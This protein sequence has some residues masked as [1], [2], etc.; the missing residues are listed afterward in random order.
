MKGDK[1]AEMEGAKMRV[2][3]WFPIVVLAVLAAVG[4]CTPKNV[5]TS[6]PTAVP[7]VSSGNPVPTSPTL[8]PEHAAWAKVVEAAKKEGLLTIYGSTGFAGDKGRITLAAFRDKYSIRVESLNM[9]G[10]QIV[11][12]VKVEERVSQPIAD[13]AA[14][15]TSSGTELSLARLVTKVWPE[16]PEMS[17]RSIFKVDPFHTPEGDVL[18]MVMSTLGTMVNTNLV[19][20]EEEPRSYVDLLG[21]RWKSKRILLTDPRGGGGGGF[22]FFS[23]LRY[24]RVLDDDYYRRFVQQEPILWGGS[25][26]EEYNMLA[27]GEAH[28]IPAAGTNSVAYLI[29]EG[30]PLKLLGMK[31][32]NLT[33]GDSISMIKGAPHPNAAKLFVNWI[34]SKEGQSVYAKAGSMESMRKDVPDFLDPRVKLQPSPQKLLPQNYSAA[35][36]TS[37][38]HRERTAETFLGKK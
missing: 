26:T 37:Q 22:M 27:K 7:Q 5:P 32:G 12:R 33:Q 11:E 4:A 14:T 30:A 38:Y 34:F 35:E 24:Y 25:T 2:S 3:K 17:D 8:S 20:L 18:V 31:E 28:L 13:L 21:P 1:K 15:G 36:A 23:L 29:V 16:L 19:K 10:R 6:V 9:P